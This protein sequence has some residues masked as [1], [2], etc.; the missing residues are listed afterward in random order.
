MFG[1]IALLALTLEKRCRQGEG[2]RTDT[3][4]HLHLLSVNVPPIIEL[5]VAVDAHDDVDDVDNLAAFLWCDDDDDLF[6][7]VA[8]AFDGGVAITTKPVQP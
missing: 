2:E 5:L 1:R 3:H 4:R 7:V 8:V 6:L